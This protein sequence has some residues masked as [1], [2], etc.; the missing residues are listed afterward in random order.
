MKKITAFLKSQVIEIKYGGWEVFIRNCLSAA[1][2]L[3]ALLTV[4]LARLL[5]PLILIRLAPLNSDRMGSFGAY[6]DSYLCERKMGMHCGRITDL[7][8]YTYPICNLQLKKMFRPHLK[9]LP[10]PFF[11]NLVFKI[12]SS[13][14]GGRQHQVPFYYIDA[15]WKRGVSA[16]N[17]AFDPQEELYGR[18][19]MRRIGIP[20][21]AGFVCFHT[22]DSAYLNSIH[23]GNDF[24]Y[25]D[26][27]DA[28]I[29]DFI[30]AA[31]ELTR[32]GYFAVRMGAVVREKLDTA[33]PRIIDYAV[34][35]RTDFLDLYL[36]GK[37]SFFILVP[38]GIA[39]IPRIFRRPIV[40][41]NWV[42]LLPPVGLWNPGDLVILK[43]FRLRGENRF[44][45]FREALKVGIT[46][47]WGTADF[48][49]AGIELVENT[50]EEIKDAAVEMEERLKGSWRESREDA[51]LQELFLSLLKD[52]A[53]AWRNTALRG[54][55]GAKFLRENQCLLN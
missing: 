5:R 1:L 21:G 44:L 40:W 39:E 15:H 51:Q 54:R 28:K 3:P 38:S 46:S 8:Y 2:L 52:E 26:Y 27:R 4:C 25:H 55:V 43:K 47:S 19:E 16:P 23:P 49:K 50:P 17:I 31:E 33:N 24:S 36:G 22:R 37:C 12:N 20:H 13:L 10:W 35:Y 53:S 9:I 7:F 48:A 11:F 18:A 41:T 29:A 42:F 32:R 6:I 45:T 14:P 30:P 34:R